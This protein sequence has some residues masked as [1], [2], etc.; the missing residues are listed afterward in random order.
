MLLVDDHA[1]LRDGLKAMLSSV[2]DIQVVA[3]ASDGREAVDEAVRMQPDVIVMD[4]A[5]PVMDGLQATLEI[6]RR[7]PASRI[8][9]LTQHDNKEYIFPLLKA[10]AAGYLL[11]KAAGTELVSAIRA[12]AE[13]GTFLHPS[14]A[15]AVVEGYVRGSDQGDGL[16]RLTER[17][18]Q[19]LG[20]VAEGLSNQ[21]IADRLILSV[22]TVMGH[23]ANVMQ[24]LDLHNRTELVKYAI[25]NGLVRVDS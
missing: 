24:K 20:L 25:R 23:R 16:D 17:E 14:V 11:K 3:E 21:E 12:V 10:G 6:K 13:G 1:M 4:M 7:A 15:G 2:G 5:M 18:T 22:K 8:I 9:I 19:V